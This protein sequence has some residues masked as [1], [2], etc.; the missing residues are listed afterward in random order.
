MISRRSLA[1]LLSGAV[2]V[3]LCR[4]APTTDIHPTYKQKKDIAEVTVVGTK[5]DPDQVEVSLSGAVSVTLRLEGSSTLEVDPVQ[6]VT[7]S[8]QWKERGRQPP[9]V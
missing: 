3:G 9:Q 6:A 4:T 8:D 7:A 5:T 2:M 1:V